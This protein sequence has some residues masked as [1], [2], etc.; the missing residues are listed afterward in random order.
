MRPILLAAFGW[1]ALHVPANA[2]MRSETV[3][4]T[5]TVTTELTFHVS[6]QD[7][8]NVSFFVAVSP[9]GQSTLSTNITGLL[10]VQDA[11]GI[12]VECPVSQTVETNSLTFT[13]TLH[14]KLLGES[15]FRVKSPVRHDGITS[16]TVYDIRLRDF[17]KQ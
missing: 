14:K 12:V 9:T 6:A 2:R 16:G 7:H 10:Q 13:F 17:M 3:V 8:G 11:A 4:P 15:T 5:N 1:L